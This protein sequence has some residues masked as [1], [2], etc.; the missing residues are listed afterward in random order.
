MKTRHT[1]LAFLFLA[2]SPSLF[3]VLA[4]DTTITIDANTP[5]ATAFISQVTLHTSDV[6]AIKSIGFSIAPKAGSA[7]RALSG[8][9]SAAYLT[10]RDFLQVNGDI[11]L[12]VYGLY[13]GTTNTVTLTYTFTDG[14]SKQATTTITA[15]VYRNSC[16]LDEPTIVQARA[17]N[18][19]LSYDYMFVRGSCPG[20]PV[21]I[22]TD[23]VIRWISPMNTNINMVV[24]S[25]GFFDN[26]VYITD[27]ANLYREDLDGTVTLVHNY[28]DLGV[29]NFH[30][31]IDQGK[32]GI[33][34]DADTVNFTE[35]VN[36]EVDAAGNV[37]KT[38]NM[39]KI[40]SAAMIAG[41][42]DPSQ[43]VYAAPIDWFHNN[44]VT[45]RRSDDS[46]IISSRENFVIT[47][48][49]ATND[50]K[51]ILGDET[52]HW[53]QFPS[54]AQFSLNLGANTLPPIGEHG[55]GITIDN[56]LLLMDNGR[57]S[58]FQ[59]PPGINRDF[60]IPRKYDLDLATATAIDTHE[61]PGTED[62][63]SQFCGSAY[64]DA[65]AN[66]VVDYAYILDNGGGSHAELLGYDGTGAK[67][68]DYTYPGGI[69]DVAYNTLP[70]HLES[71]KFPTVGPQT[72]NLSTRA[73]VG[74]GDRA[75]IE[76][77]IITGNGPKSVVLRALGASLGNNGV[78]G[79]LADP[80]LQIFDAAGIL[81]ATNDNWEADPNAAK[82]A[83]AQLAP[84]DPSEAALFQ[85][86][87]PG[88]Y[89][90][91]VT[92]VGGG[93]GISLL[94]A[95][96]VSPKSGSVLANVSARG[97]VGTGDNVL[98]SG[99][100]VGDVASST[101]VVR[102]LGSSLPP[103]LD[104]LNDPFLTV[105]DENGVSVG[106]NDNW[107][108]DPNA[109]DVQRQGLAPTNPTES[110]ILLNLPA[111]AYTGVVRSASGGS[112]IGLVEVYDLL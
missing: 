55:T 46:I 41:G 33:V 79:T 75:L 76:G 29:V 61:Y 40:I 77:F 82:V 100:I 26:A 92:G 20:S 16:S 36:L 57:N 70:L 95:Y 8:E 64:E 88:A 83:G 91:V 44:A 2:L 111:G 50:I 93:S 42:D 85:T 12:P 30:H 32:F 34:L 19:S 1:I 103:E 38:W 17:A 10:E 63:Y 109:G 9:Y 5:G 105:I 14:S 80:V 67:A 3:A 35:C 102:A 108:G 72:L 87:A 86:L 89:T 74:A 84:A 4:D 56:D 97:F 71:T 21:V 60:S 31:N 51:W 112:G 104:R 66:Y 52:K 96:D 58:G 47:I 18:S 11:F 106:V 99:F 59:M 39:A 110:A 62:V 6:A 43:F 24:Q 94:E 73:L 37:L 27:E 81:V 49:Y 28:S 69:C 90:A 68:F 25:A 48:D 45:Y 101:V 98:I 65:K 22:D 13:S 23:G 107:E 7:T 78:A 54:L 15:A 53:Y